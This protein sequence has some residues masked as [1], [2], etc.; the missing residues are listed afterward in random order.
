M[1]AEL[2]S[3]VSEVENEFGGMSDEQFNWKPN[4][5]S[6]SIGQCLDHLVITNKK[7]IHN[8]EKAVNGEHTRTFWERAPWLP[9]FLGRF[10]IKTI[11]PA[12]LKKNKA[13]KSF[14]PSQSEVDKSIIGVYTSTSESIRG[15]MKACENED[16]EKMIIT[17]P[18]ASFATYSLHDAFK[19]VVL[20]DSRHFNQ[21]KR[22]M[23]NAGFPK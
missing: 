11:D 3:I 22:V 2:E 4:P 21:A 17:S 18:V 13:P 5:K 10:L 8:I 1:I 7:E 19:I 16:T 9:G 12:N 15:F 6:W 14:Q 20:H 23:E